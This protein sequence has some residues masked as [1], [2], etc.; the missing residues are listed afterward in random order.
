MYLMPLGAAG[1]IGASCFY[2]NINGTGIILDC[3]IH[4]RKYGSESLPDLDELEN[5]PLDY[6]IIT[7]AHQDHIGALPFLIK[8]FP[9]LKI[10][11]TSPT[12]EIAN[13]VLHN[14]VRLIK[15]QLRDDDRITPYSHDEIDLLI[16]SIT[17]HS[18]K[19][20]INIRGINQPE[21]FKIMLQFFDA[22]HILGSASVLITHGSERFFYTGDINF[23]NLSLMKP[24]EYPLGKINYILSE[25]TY[26]ETSG[27]DLPEWNEEASNLADEINKTINDGGSVLI[28]VF[29]LGKFQEILS[30]LNEYF[31]KGKL[32]TNVI[33]TGGLGRRLNYLYDNFRY[34]VNYRKPNFELHKV[35]T[36]NLDQVRNPHEFIKN[37]GIVLTSSGM[38]MPDTASYNLARLWLQQK[39]F[40]IFSVGYMDPESPGYTIMN[41][42]PGDTITLPGFPENKIDVKC[43]IKKF[44]FTS[45]ARREDLTQKVISS[46]PEKIILVHGDE[47]AQSGLGKLFLEID[48]SLKIYTPGKSRK[49]DLRL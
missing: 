20:E 43:R 16:K 26:G 49:I 44:R 6:V 25:S 30:T 2:L 41:S 40:A 34:N 24:A 11:T 14:S 28:P 23:S 37:P 3:G 35:D 27:Y 9:Y 15:K 10:L 17:D 13:Y 4:P 18:Y 29:A 31:I 7:H 8:K 48:N 45:H 5:H 46:K 38:M 12:K 42:K 39:K 1:E 21:S 22:G 36:I 47:A 19:E 33:Y 32:S